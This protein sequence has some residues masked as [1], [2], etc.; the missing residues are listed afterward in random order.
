[1]LGWA[2]LCQN[3]TPCQQVRSCQSH[4]ES[5]AMLDRGRIRSSSWY[6]VLHKPSDPKDDLE[7]SSSATNHTPEWPCLAGP[8]CAR[9]THHVNKSGRA[10]VTTNL[11]QS[12]TVAESG[13]VAGMK[14]F[15]NRQTR[16]MIWKSHHQPK[17]TPQSEHA[18]LGHAVPEP[19]T[20]STSQVVPKSQRVLGKAG[21]W[22]NQV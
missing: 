17:I 18:W 1:M 22:Q 7:I 2:M 3:H 15:T 14:F 21:P 9:T 6:E 10:K 20:I 5:W 16:K 8:C 13:L 4:N 12:W 11:G 19:H